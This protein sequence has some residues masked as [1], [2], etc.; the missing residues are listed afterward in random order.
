MNPCKITEDL[1]PLYVEGTCNPGSREY[2][3][4]HVKSCPKCRALLDSMKESVEIDIPKQDAK[5]NF[6]RLSAFLV[7]RRVLTITLCV[8]LSLAVLTVAL[9]RPV[10]NPWL[11][12][13]LD[14]PLE[15]IDVQLSRLPDG[16]LHVRFTYTNDEYDISSHG[17]E[18]PGSRGDGITRL[19]VHHHRILDWITFDSEKSYSRIIWTPD[20]EYIPKHS[21][22]PAETLI[23]VGSDGERVLW[24]MGDELPPADAEAEALLQQQIEKGHLIPAEE[25][26]QKRESGE[27]SFG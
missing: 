21:M 20:S 22:S 7:R 9:W 24:Q 12:G 8:L 5:K 10:L 1:L 11:F 14:F 16:S 17:I 25:Y 26:W 27:I 6:R 3:E 15:D 13:Q 18:G 4:E 23:L 2:V 19:T